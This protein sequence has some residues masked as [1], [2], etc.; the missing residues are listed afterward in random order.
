MMSFSN[1]TILAEYFLILGST[2]KSH[3]HV[4]MFQNEELPVQKG[5]FTDM[6]SLN[7]ITLFILFSNFITEEVGGLG[8]WKG[9]FMRRDIRSRRNLIRPVQDRGI[10]SI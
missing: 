9:L 7:N 4:L 5:I 3:Q 6:Q 8:G 1:E 2:Y 10:C